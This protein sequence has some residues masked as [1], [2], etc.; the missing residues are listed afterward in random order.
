MVLKLLNSFSS[1]A[2]KVSYSFNNCNIFFI[3]IGIYRPPST[4]INTI[5]QLAE[6]ISKY[7]E[8]EVINL[9]LLSSSSGY[10]KE[11]F[12]GLNFDQIINKPTRPNVNNLS[13]STLID[14]IFTNRIS[15]ISKT[16]VFKL[17]I[18]DHCPIACVRD[19]RFKK[20]SSHIV[21]KRNK[22]NF[23]EQ[24]FL[25]DLYNSD[26][27][28]TSEIPDTDLA[29]DCFLKSFISVLDRHAP[30]KMMRVKNRSNPWFTTELSSLLSVRNKAWAL[31]KQTKMYQTW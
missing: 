16:G 20:T 28:L 6:L 13:K 22:K 24:E 10:L 29:L 17:G 23:N 3:V 1:L 4:D 19:I 25:N 11:V 31:A 18:S 12:S 26:I 2:L 9:D 30:F 21:V 5:S 27:H 8:S 14:L 7:S 15:K